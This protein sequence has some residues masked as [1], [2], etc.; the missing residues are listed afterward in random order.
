MPKREG[1]KQA[2]GPLLLVGAGKRPRELGA[3]LTALA[4][5]RAT[6]NVAFEPQPAFGLQDLEE[7]LAQRPRVGTLIL[8]YERVPAG[9]V[10]FV[11]R[12]LERNTGWRLLVLGD[13]ARDRRARALLALPRV[14]WIPW[15]PDLDQV[16]ALLE[17]TPAPDDL[18]RASPRP[19][20]APAESG[21][22]GSEELDLGD[23]LEEL[24]ASASVAGDGAPRTQYRCDQALPLRRE[25]APLA[26]GLASLLA[27]ARGCAGPDGE[28]QASAEP[29]STSGDPPE[30]VRLR[31]DFPTG[32][33]REEDWPGLLDVPFAGEPTVAED[34]ARAS[35]GAVALRAAGC[36]VLLFTR[37][38]DRL[39]VELHVASGP[40]APAADEPARAK[41]EDPFA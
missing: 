25:R 41:A 21:A 4:A 10:G 30:T 18:E 5:V 17:T 3:V 11:R 1:A 24:L 36:R 27:L 7:L 9:D 14:Q 32:P 12:F 15:P 35:R 40:L 6:D 16:G 37:S 2:S 34:V 19:P 33:L 26:E 38:P 8:D 29:A 39:R 13:E 31:I 20:A 28:V 23:L 22:T